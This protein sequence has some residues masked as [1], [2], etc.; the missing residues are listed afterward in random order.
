MTLLS[1][2]NLT[3]HRNGH[4]VVRDVSLSIGP[5][6][7]VGLVGPNGAG[8]TTL[9]RAALGLLAFAGSASLAELSPRARAKAA[10]WLPQTR[11]I[12]WPVSVETLVSLGRTP[13]LAGGRRLSVA[14][15]QAVQRAIQHMDLGDFADRP[16][17]ELSGG[18]QA[19]VLIARVLA[20]EAPL[21]IAD[22][23]GAGLDPAHQFGLMRVFRDLAAMGQSVF[24]SLH[25]LGLA[26]K[27][28][29][30][31][32]M[33]DQGQLVADGPPIEVLS[34]ARLRDVFSI[35]GHWGQG[36]EGEYFHVVE[37]V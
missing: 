18:E 20:Q 8:K 16:A 13:Y 5:G 17:N 25:D 37:R 31:L 10:A 6:E 27:H 1:I 11:E 33:L 26:A 22:E 2:E 14:D 15:S 21:I 30:R 23:P 7:V 28:C 4:P 36:P 3:V 19:R 24:V 32:V 34:D 35:G 9:M 12:T 29:T